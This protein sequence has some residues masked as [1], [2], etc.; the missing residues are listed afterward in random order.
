MNQE[1]DRELFKVSLD[2]I[3][4]Y[5]SKDGWYISDDF[6]RFIESKLTKGDGEWH[7]VIV[8][9]V[10]DKKY[11]TFEWG[12]DNG[13]YYYEPEWTEVFPKTIITTIYE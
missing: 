1:K 13:K 6:Y 3:G 5:T 7:I 11:F 10:R 4:D 8:Q 9:R 12:Y 2:I